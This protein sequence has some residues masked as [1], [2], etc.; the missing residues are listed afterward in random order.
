[1]AKK[2]TKADKAFIDKIKSIGINV[3]GHSTKPPTHCSGCG[4]PLQKVGEMIGDMGGTHV[5]GDVYACGPL[6]L[7]MLPPGLRRR[8]ARECSEH[9]KNE[10][11]FSA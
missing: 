10:Q 2:Q 6:P 9:R 1:M 4:D 11:S 8:A 5:H 3:A 7:S